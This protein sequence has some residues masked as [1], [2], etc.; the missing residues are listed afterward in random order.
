MAEHPN[1]DL[2]ALTPDGSV[3]EFSDLPND[4]DVHDAFGG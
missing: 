4:P 3:A 1:A 2:L